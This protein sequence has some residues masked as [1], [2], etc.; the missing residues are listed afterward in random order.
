MKKSKA[1][2]FYQYLPPWRVD[3]FNEMG[4]LY[5]LT[6][7]FTDAECEGFT[8]N[9]Q[10]LLNKLQNINT[11]FLNNGF[12]IGNR[13]V[14]LGILKLIRK[15]KPDIVFSHEY[16][17]TSVLVAL[18]KKLKMCSYKYYITTSDNLEIAK[19]VNGAKSIARKFILNNSNGIIVYSQNVKQWYQKKF[20]LLQVEVCPNIQNPQSLLSYRPQFEIIIKQNKEKYNIQDEIIILYIGRL[21]KIKGLDLLLNALSKVQNKNFKLIIVGTGK[22]KKGLEEQAKI[23]KIEEKVVFTGYSNG[24]ELYAWYDVANFLILPSLYE[25]FGAVVN[26]ALIYGCPVIASQYI[27]AVDFI[28]SSNGIVFNPLKKDEFIKTLNIA[29]Q[30]YP[31]RKGPA[32]NLMPCTFNEYIKVFHKL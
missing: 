16:S 23:L 28:N 24:I 15:H 29:F 18:Y 12:K 9:R 25:P 31:K 21:V 7:V 14:R 13:P 8:Y 3:I 5:D 22:E 27:G 32:E 17:P 26:E 19:A 20:P 2:V 11:V 6:I 30:K 4:K 1:L 10:D